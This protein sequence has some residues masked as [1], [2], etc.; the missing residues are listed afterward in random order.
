MENDK[1]D[2][3]VVD[4]SPIKEQKTLPFLKRVSN[5]EKKIENLEKRMDAIIRSLRSRG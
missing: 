3:G 1:I 5:L 4:F 2:T